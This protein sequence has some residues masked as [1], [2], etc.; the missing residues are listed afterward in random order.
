MTENN[1]KDDKNLPGHIAIIMDGNG[2]WAKKRLLPRTMG[3][4]EGIKSA[5]AIAKKCAELKIPYLTLFA[6][7]TEN[8]NRPKKEVDTLWKFL[9]EFLQKE[10][11][12]LIEKGVRLRVIGFS[13]RIPEDIMNNIRY[14]LKKSAKNDKMNLI[15]ALNY[16]G[17][18]EIVNAVNKCVELAKQGGLT[19]SKIDEESFKNFLFTRDIPD[20]DLLI[21]T[22]GEI[23]ISNFLL[24]QMAY[25]ELYFSDKYWPEFNE[26]ELEKAIKS[27]QNRSRRF[28]AVI[29]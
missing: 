12:N 10:A 18:S 11:H 15:V 21:R 7:S 29:D 2:R 8:W 13:E 26:I 3:H 1:G 6:F 16:S 27:Y 19:Q 5:Q 28:G 4:R 17:R 9:D 22:G 25:T 24:Y 23:R 20:P 14:V